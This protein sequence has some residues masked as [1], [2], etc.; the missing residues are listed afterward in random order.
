MQR[1]GVTDY[2]TATGKLKKAFEG[3]NLELVHR[4][5]SSLRK[6]SLKEYSIFTHVFVYECKISCELFLFNL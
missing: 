6:P 5:T 2:T 3:H 4:S 1:M